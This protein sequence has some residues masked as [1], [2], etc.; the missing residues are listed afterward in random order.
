M[1][2]DIRALGL[3]PCGACR[4]LIALPEGCAHWPMRVYVPV[5]GKRDTNDWLTLCNRILRDVRAG[6][7]HPSYDVLIAARDGKVVPGRKAHYVVYKMRKRGL[8]KPVGI[9]QSRPYELTDSGAH[10]L[11]VIEAAL[12]QRS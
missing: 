7:G 3:F 12:S 6:V 2:H 10:L 11:D 1:T 9:D 8:L 4:A 5:D